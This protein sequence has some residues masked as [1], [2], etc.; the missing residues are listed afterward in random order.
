MRMACLFQEGYG[1]SAED[2]PDLARP[3]QPG[4]TLFILLG[5]KSHRGSPY[6]FTDV[7]GIVILVILPTRFDKLPLPNNEGESIP[8]S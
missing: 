1:V 2:L 8:F 7:P 6:G 4:K 5:D 3:V